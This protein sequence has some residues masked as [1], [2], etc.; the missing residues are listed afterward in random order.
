MSKGNFGGG[1]DVERRV[2][3]RTPSPISRYLRGQRPHHVTNRHLTAFT[4]YYFIPSQPPE[5]AAYQII[6]Q[7]N[8]ILPVHTPNLGEG[9]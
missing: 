9:V 8:G 3:Y 1:S 6:P 4:S 5:M 2:R 7:A